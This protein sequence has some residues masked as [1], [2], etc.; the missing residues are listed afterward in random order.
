MHSWDSK[1]KRS[2]VVPEDRCPVY[3]PEEDAQVSELRAQLNLTDDNALK[4]QLKMQ[5]AELENAAN[6]RYWSTLDK[7]KTGAVI[8]YEYGQCYIQRG[9]Q[10]VADLPKKTRAGSKDDLQAMS[11][12]YSAALVRSMSCERSLA[13]QAALCISHKISIAMLTWTLCRATFSHRSYDNTPMKITLTDNSHAL[14]SDSAAKEEGKAWQHLQK[15][16]AAWEAS[17]PENWSQ[18]FHWL[19]DWSSEYVLGLLGYCS[20]TAVCCFQDRVYGTSQTS[21]LDTLETAM[22]FDLSDWWQPTAEGFFKRMSKDQIVGALTEAGKTGNAKDAE[23]MK[24]GDATD[25]AE[26]AL[27]GSRWVPEWMKPLKTDAAEECSTGT[28][29]SEG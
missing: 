29:D 27:K 24:K 1:I 28:K 8:C 22:G 16:K 5:M 13:V 21:N 4:P 19:L 6:K 25:F 26:Q 10:R 20:A 14:V 7:D 15:E 11:E 18:D 9:V 23:K 3:T 2:Y 17:L 12:G